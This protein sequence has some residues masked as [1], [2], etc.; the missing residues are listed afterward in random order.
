M[1][2]FVRFSLVG[3]FAFLVDAAMLQA[4]VSL[5]LDPY[6]GRI[7]SYLCAVTTTWWLNRTYTFTLRADTSRLHEWARYAISQLG[8]GSVNYAIYAA[9]VFGVPLVA[10]HPVLGVAAGSIGGLVVNFLLA[11]RYV[12]R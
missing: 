2:Q 3:G 10:R 5:G 1:R 6:A 4:A 9:L 11:R 8:G 12:F 7:L